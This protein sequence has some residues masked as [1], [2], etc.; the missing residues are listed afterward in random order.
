MVQSGQDQA[1]SPHGLVPDEFLTQAV[2]ED[3]AEH[4]NNIIF[5]KQSFGVLSLP[6]HVPFC[7]K[8]ELLLM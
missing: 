4:L 1:C 8:S 5:V 7:N 2:G 3:S 6:F